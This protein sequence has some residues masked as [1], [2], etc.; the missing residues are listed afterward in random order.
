[1]KNH[2]VHARMLQHILQ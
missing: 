2:Y 1:M